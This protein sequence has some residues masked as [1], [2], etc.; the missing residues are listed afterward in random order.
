MKGLTDGYDLAVGLHLLERRWAGPEMLRCY[1]ETVH[2]MRPVFSAFSPHELAFL[3]WYPSNQ[4]L[5]GRTESMVETDHTGGT[6]SE[7]R[8]DRSM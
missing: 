4:Y 3:H 2:G 8:L 7:L 5:L 1:P 6:F